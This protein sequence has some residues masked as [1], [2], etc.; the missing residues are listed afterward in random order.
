MLNRRDLE[1]FIG[2]VTQTEKKKSP[3]LRMTTAN[4]RR[5]ADG[6]AFLLMELQDQQKALAESQK[7][8]A[9]SQVTSIELDGGSF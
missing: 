3:E 1:E 9:D 6:L 2:L 5:V 4:A 7:K 8:L